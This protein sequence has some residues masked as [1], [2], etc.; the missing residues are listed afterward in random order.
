MTAMTEPQTLARI[1]P[2]RQRVGSARRPLPRRELRA[3]LDER[4]VTQVR[5]VIENVTPQVHGGRFAVKAVVGDIVD[6]AAD[7]W[8]DQGTSERAPSK[9]VLIEGLLK[10]ELGSPFE[11]PKIGQKAPN[12]TLKTHDGKREITVSDYQGKKPVVLIFGSFT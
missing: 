6:V 11:G 10:G 2:R 5:I 3:W 4:D 7:I 12:F 8:K 9:L 1:G